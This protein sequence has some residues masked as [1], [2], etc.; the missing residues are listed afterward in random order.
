MTY[1]TDPAYSRDLLARF[2]QPRHAGTLNGAGVRRGRAGS[3]AA[4]AEVEW[5]LRFAGG[6]VAEAR[7]RAFGPPALIAA[8]DWRA[9]QLAGAD[10]QALRAGWALVA[11]RALALPPEALGTLLVAEDALTRLAA[12]FGDESQTG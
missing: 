8:C 9:E 2:F 3:R 12:E 4:G 6:R 1:E 11:A 7:F 10:V 5:S